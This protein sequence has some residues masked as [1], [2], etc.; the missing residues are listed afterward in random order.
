MADAQTQENPNDN[1]DR[2]SDNGERLN[3]ATMEVNN[4][5]MPVNSDHDIE[6]MSI[7][8]KTFTFKQNINEP[9]K[10][11][12]VKQ[13]II[14]VNFSNMESR[15]VQNLYAYQ[16]QYTRQITSN[17]ESRYVQNQYAYQHQYTRQ[18]T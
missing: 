5:N 8:P 17:M 2:N 15:Y 12:E 1:D 11:C 18:I 9:K 7:N 14:F 4:D 10:S 13:Y 16:H 3:N 6:S